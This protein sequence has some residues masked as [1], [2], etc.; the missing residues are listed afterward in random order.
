MLAIAFVYSSPEVDNESQGNHQPPYTHLQRHM[1]V[2]DKF[3]RV[4]YKAWTT[5]S[6]GVLN[7]SV[8]ILSFRRHWWTCRKRIAL[9]YASKER[10]VRRPY[11][12]T[13]N[14]LEY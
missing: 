14:S 13:T 5:V 10:G 12:K 8:L 6:T 4:T 2:N 11:N 3:F 1:L 9:A 7:A